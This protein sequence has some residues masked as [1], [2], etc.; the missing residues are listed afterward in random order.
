MTFQAP[1]PAPGWERLSKDEVTALGMHEDFVGHAY[2]DPSRN[3]IMVTCL[4]FWL[5]RKP[6]PDKN[7][8]LTP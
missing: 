3:A 2:R 6:L 4:D 1:P 7:P 8:F 5:E